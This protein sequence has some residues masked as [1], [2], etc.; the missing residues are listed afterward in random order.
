MRLPGAGAPER[1]LIGCGWDP[2]GHNYLVC[3]AAGPM[4]RCDLQ[5]RETTIV[6]EEAVPIR[7]D[8]LVFSWSSDG[9]RLRDLAQV[10]P[11]KP[12]DRRAGRNPSKASQIPIWHSKTRALLLGKDP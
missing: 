3:L 12:V 7:E 5:K 11:K 1:D 8:R 9:R 4:L 2:G 6:D 10:R